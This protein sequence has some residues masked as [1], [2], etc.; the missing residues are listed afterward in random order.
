MRYLLIC[1]L[2]VGCVKASADVPEPTDEVVIVIPDPPKPEPKPDEDESGTPAPPQVPA[3]DY[4]DVL[5]Y[6]GPGCTVCRTM[7]TD[8]G[9]NGDYSKP[10]VLGGFRFVPCE[11]KSINEFPTLYF[12]SS[13]SET[14]WRRLV[15]W[16]SFAKFKQKYD[17]AQ[18][19]QT[20]EKVPEKPKTGYQMQFGSRSMWTYPGSIENHLKK[21]HGFSA[22]ELR[23]LSRVELEQLHSNEHERGNPRRSYG[24]RTLSYRYRSYCPTGT[25][26]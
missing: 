9:A 12:K 8:L 10:A 1:L 16:E 26:P 21:S 11:D 15:G 23:G 25:C 5:V 19:V 17:K 14:G 24:R 18:A 2:L 4:T 22:A 20:V 13:T 6:V 7:F 3:V